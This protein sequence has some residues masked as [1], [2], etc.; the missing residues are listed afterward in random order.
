[1]WLKIFSIFCVP[2]HRVGRK[3]KLSQVE[4]F[5]VLPPHCLL[6]PSYQVLEKDQSIEDEVSH[7]SRYLCDLDTCVT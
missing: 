4:G 7:V 5:Y 6:S 1:M 3:L 2:I